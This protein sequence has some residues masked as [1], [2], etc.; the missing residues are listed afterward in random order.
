MQEWT[1]ERK[2]A[3]P[4]VAMVGDRGWLGFLVVGRKEGE[5]GGDMTTR[6][7]K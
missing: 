5:G 7:K 1:R 6:R 2:T 4:K 3:M